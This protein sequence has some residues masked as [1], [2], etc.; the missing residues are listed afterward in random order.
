MQ[1]V[2]FGATGGIGRTLVEQALN[3]GHK[4]TALV[5]TPQKLQLNGSSIDIVQGDVKDV[6]A[7]KA[8][9]GKN[10]DA[11]LSALGVRPGEGSVVAPGTANIIAAMREAGVRRFIG[12]SAS[13]IYV[14]R[15]DTPLLRI[16]KPILQRVLRASYDDIRA[17][18]IE[19]RNSSLDWSLIVPPRLVD[20]PLTKRYRSAV[21]HNVPNGFSI[22][23]ADVAYSMLQILNNRSTFESLVFVAN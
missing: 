10:S 23:R 9:I 12:V 13:A 20:K 7:V 16:A 15:Y 21:G 11:V 22:R 18:E 5:R 6:D 19:L 8:A 2:I 1:I 17:A 3:A 4:V 14:D